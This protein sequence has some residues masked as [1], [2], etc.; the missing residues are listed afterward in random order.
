MYFP[1]SIILS[2]LINKEGMSVIKIY[3]VYFVCVAD[4]GCVIFAGRAVNCA[5]EWQYLSSINRDACAAS[6][7]V[8]SGEKQLDIR[9]VL[10]FKATRLRSNIKVCNWFHSRKS[11]LTLLPV[12]TYKLKLFNSESNR[13]IQKIRKASSHIPTAGVYSLPFKIP[14]RNQTR[15]FAFI[16]QI[17]IVRVF[18]LHNKLH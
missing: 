17:T 14:L 10:S 4:C 8:F 15:A 6:R 18:S 9:W 2:K 12:D 13:S 5:V 16:L 1:S 11:T 7:C 3:T